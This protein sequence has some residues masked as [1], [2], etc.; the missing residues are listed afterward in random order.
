MI[1]VK[2]Y[3]ERGAR[4]PEKATPSSACYDEKKG[5]ETKNKV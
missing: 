2:I 1:P 5:E 4:L 3:A